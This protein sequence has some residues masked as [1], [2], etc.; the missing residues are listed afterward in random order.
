MVRERQLKQLAFLAY[1]MQIKIIK[2]CSLDYNLQFYS[3]NGFK[4]L[5]IE[6]T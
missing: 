2:F 5:V 1:K 4:A 6:K 3:T